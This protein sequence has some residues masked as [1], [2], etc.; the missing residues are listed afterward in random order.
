M[1]WHGV[2][3][4]RTSTPSE[5]WVS[6]LPNRTDRI[7]YKYIYN[8]N[9]S[10]KH[11]HLYRKHETY[12]LQPSAKQYPLAPKLLASSAPTTLSCLVGCERDNT[13]YLSQWLPWCKHCVTHPQPRK[14]RVKT[15]NPEQ[16]WHAPPLC[17]R[18]P[19]RGVFERKRLR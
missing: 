14:L 5:V 16:H 7:K 12:F 9:R 15:Q 10:L 6:V 8:P 11:D 17:S 2:L 3:Y 1:L 18:Q 13:Y 4:R 19:V